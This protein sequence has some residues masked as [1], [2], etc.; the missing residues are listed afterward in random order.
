MFHSRTIHHKINKLHERGLRIVYKDKLST[1]EQLL[2]K[3]KSFSIHERNLQKLAMEM[4]KVK[5]NLCPKPFQD[6]FVR[7]ERGKGDFVI[8]KISTVNRGEEAIRYRGPVTWELVPEEIRASE[9]FAI[10]KDRIKNWK[11]VGCKCRLC[12]E[13]VKDLGYGFFNGETFVPK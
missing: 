1:F 8:P 11:P 3:D 4:Y 13:Y 5:N 2:E 12:K 7:K 10:F 6:L 9:S